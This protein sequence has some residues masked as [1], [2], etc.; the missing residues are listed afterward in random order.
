MLV[1]LMG[2]AEII[3]LMKLI[4]SGIDEKKFETAMNF[5]VLAALVIVSRFCF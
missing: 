4:V 5:I 3:M 2:M 1:A